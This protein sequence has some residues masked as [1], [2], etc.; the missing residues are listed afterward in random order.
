[1]PEKVNYGA[2][3]YSRSSVICAKDI[4]GIGGG[5]MWK[6]IAPRRKWVVRGLFFGG[7]AMASAFFGRPVVVSAHHSVAGYVDEITEAEGELV[8]LEWRNPHIRIALKTMNTDGEEEVRIMHGNSLYNLQRAGVTQ[9]LFRIGERVRVAGRRSSRDELDFLAT[10]ILFADG[11]E[12]LL[13]RTQPRWSEQILGGRDLLVERG[14]NGGFTGDGKGIFRV[15]S[16]PRGSAR[17]V[18]THLPFQE[19]AIAARESWDTFDNFATR[20]EP[21]GMPRIMINPH[22]FEF[23]DQGDQITLRTELY[24]IE[25]TIHLNRSE[26]PPNEPWSKLGYSVG[27]RKDGILVVRTSRINWPFFDTIGT[28][29]SEAVEIVERFTV[30]NDQGRL[31]FHITVTDPETFTEPATIE[32]Y[33]LALGDTIPIY[34]C[35][36]D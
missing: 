33:W 30:S 5:D 12:A 19:S 16:V 24:D 32:G 36:T 18:V 23:L 27:E 26:P 10:N 9:D 14:L 2:L 21:E 1:M 35:Q 4:M 8:G 17:R 29:Q 34:G 13:W 11:R 15:W 6:R 31:D 20:C 7:L 25:R 3:T 28:P 22:P